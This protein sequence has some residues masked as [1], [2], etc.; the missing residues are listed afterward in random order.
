MADVRTPLVSG[1]N[2]RFLT[3]GTRPAAPPGGLA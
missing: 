1:A 3:L 2:I